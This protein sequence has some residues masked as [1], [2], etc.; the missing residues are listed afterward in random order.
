MISVR[1]TYPPL[2]SCTV[3]CVWPFW[4][5]LYCIEV[6]SL[7]WVALVTIIAWFYSC[8]CLCV[9]GKSANLWPYCYILPVGCWHHEVFTNG[10]R[11]FCSGSFVYAVLKLNAWLL[12]MLCWC[13]EYGLWHCQGQMPCHSNNALG[14]FLFIL[15]SLEIMSLLLCYYT[16]QLW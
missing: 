1:N 6:A 7:C 10:R 16:L 9:T 11:E 13:W 14:F 2:L 15:I 4:V 12:Q 3:A 8:L 5:Y